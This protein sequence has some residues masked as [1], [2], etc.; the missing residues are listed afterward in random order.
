MSVRIRVTDDLFLRRVPAQLAAE[1]QRQIRQMA[2]GANAMSA[3]Q[4]GDRL[5]PRLDAIE[6]V[7]DVPFELVA[8]AAGPVLGGRRPVF[9]RARLGDPL[10]P[11]D[12]MTGPGRLRD[13]IRG[14]TL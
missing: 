9:R 7:A 1:S 2:D 4:I 12:R 6:K 8:L 11:A 13:A 3:L 14:R 5:L 10:W